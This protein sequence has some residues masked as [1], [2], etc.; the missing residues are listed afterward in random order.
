MDL[1][2][3]FKLDQIGLDFF[4]LKS[5]RN[6]WVL[7]EISSSG[8]RESSEK[9]PNGFVFVTH[10]VHTIQNTGYTVVLR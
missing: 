1:R 10:L 6:F 3:G 9:T 8:K 4:V 5:D 2:L 7:S